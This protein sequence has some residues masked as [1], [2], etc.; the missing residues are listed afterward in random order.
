MSIDTEYAVVRFSVERFLPRI[1]GGVAV[2]M[3]LGTMPAH[4]DGTAV[5]ASAPPSL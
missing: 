5:S 3:L 2:L 1:L 4:A